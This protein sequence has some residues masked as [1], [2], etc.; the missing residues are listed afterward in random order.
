LDLKAADAER[1]ARFGEVFLFFLPAAAL[2]Q[3]QSSIVEM[4]GSAGAAF[5]AAYFWRWS[6]GIWQARSRA[7]IGRMPR[8]LPESAAGPS[9]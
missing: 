8:R 7:N 6:W 9:A 2:V 3:P 5:A 4:T 1:R